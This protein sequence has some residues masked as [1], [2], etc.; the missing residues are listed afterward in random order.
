ML[1]SNQLIHRQY[2][3]S[4]LWQEK[5]KQALAHYGPVCN[6]CKRYGTDV[7]HKTYERVGG[8]ELMEDLEIL[9]RSCHEAHHRVERATRTRRC[10]KR[11][12]HVSGAVRY[13]T[14]AQKR[15]L[16]QRFNFSTEICLCQS[17][18]RGQPEVVDAAAKMLGCRR[19]FGTLKLKTDYDER[20]KRL[21]IENKRKRKQRKRSEE[22]RRKKLLESP[23]GQWP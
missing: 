13:L 19:I 23:N 20:M 10:H 9:C 2:L 16:M 17:L 1:T 14:P 6:R 8:D 22:G 12:L 7:H 3:E 15:E 18:Y 21:D 11:E 5:R 4:P